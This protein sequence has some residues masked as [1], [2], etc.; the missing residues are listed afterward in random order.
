MLAQL[1]LWLPARDDGG[2]EVV[3]EVA[4]VECRLQPHFRRLA[5][6]F[7]LLVV[8]FQARLEEVAVWRAAHLP[9]DGHLPLGSGPEG[10]KL[11]IWVT[12]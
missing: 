9:Q 7:W 8:D 2:E 11:V 10:S 5:W 6:L 12:R 3:E 1:L 4:A